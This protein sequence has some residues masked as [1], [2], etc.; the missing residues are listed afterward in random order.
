MTTLPASLSL[1]LSTFPHP[2]LKKQFPGVCHLVV[3]EGSTKHDVTISN[4]EA[5]NAA[6]LSKPDLKITL[7]LETFEAILAGKLKPPKA[8]M[9]KKIKIKGKV[10][11][12]MKFQRVMDAVRKAKART[13]TAKL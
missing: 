11:L 10:G 1:L 8:F 5:T 9:E 13:T 6:P 2:K 4:G 12:A 7:S 3:E